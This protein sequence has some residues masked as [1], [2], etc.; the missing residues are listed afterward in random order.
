MTKRALGMS[1]SKENLTN[2][3][4]DSSQSVFL[5]EE[6]VQLIVET[7]CKV[8]GAAL[9]LG[10]M[11]SIQDEALLSP[12]LQRIFERVR[13][14]ADYMPFKQTEKVLN[15]ELG[16]DYMRL[17]ESLEKNPFA[18]ASIGQVHMGFLKETNEK[19]AVKI[20]YPGVAQSIQSDIDNL[21]SILNVAQLLPKQMFVENVVNVMKKELLDECDYNRE[22]ECML[23]FHEFIKND[24]VFMLPKVYDGLSTKQILITEFVEGEPFDKCMELDQEQRNHVSLV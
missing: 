8:R 22:A 23:K 11:L 16:N 6:N 9:K 17:F 21:M 10:Q 3:L 13:Q 5:T 4:I 18:A 14:S 15:T 20:Q 19:V 12:A 2:S 1:K 7:L 24:P